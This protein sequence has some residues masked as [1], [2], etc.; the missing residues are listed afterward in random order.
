MSVY[1]YLIVKVNFWC[2]GKEI[3][4]KNK[5]PKFQKEYGL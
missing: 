2:G 1:K 3:M 4:L 5:I